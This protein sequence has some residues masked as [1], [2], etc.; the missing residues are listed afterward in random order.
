MLRCKVHPQPVP[1]RQATQTVV[2]WSSQDRTV[3]AVAVDRSISQLAS[4]L[5]FVRLLINRRVVGISRQPRKG[6]QLV[7]RGHD[8]VRQGRIEGKSLGL[9]RRGDRLSRTDSIFIST[10]TQAVLR[11][12]WQVAAIGLLLAAAKAAGLSAPAATQSTTTHFNLH[13]R[14][15]APA[16]LHA[17]RRLLGCGRSLYYIDSTAGTPSPL[18]RR[19]RHDTD[20][21]PSSVRSIRL[22]E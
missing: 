2:A 17:L 5:V 10:P 20:P 16:R 19:Q 9:N 14:P 12:L 8:G 4:L 7:N 21:K 15:P 22:I 11:L 1:V 3:I 6:G 13:R 18:T